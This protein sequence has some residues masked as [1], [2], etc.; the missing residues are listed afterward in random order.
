MSQTSK[1]IL[2]IIITTIIV[3]GGTYILQQNQASPPPSDVETVVPEKVTF[4]EEGLESEFMLPSGWTYSKV[5]DQASADKM[6]PNGAGYDKKPIQ[7]LDQFSFYDQNHKEVGGIS[8]FATKNQVE[9]TFDGCWRGWNIQSGEAM[10]G[11]KDYLPKPLTWLLDHYIYAANDGL[12][13]V[14]AESC[15]FGAYIYWVPGELVTNQASLSEFYGKKPLR[16][17]AIHDA[18]MNADDFIKLVHG[19]VKS[20][21]IKN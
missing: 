16:V 15:G 1:I 5:I 3:G 6:L 13:S 17:L 9:T 14:A 12:T 10:G 19:V 4:R 20:V 18:D 11:N 8:F 21:T 7:G 2:S